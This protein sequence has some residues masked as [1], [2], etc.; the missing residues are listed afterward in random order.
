[1]TVP[2]APPALRPENP[3]SRR[4]VL[5]GPV[6][7]Y[8]LVIFAASSVSNVPALPHGVTDKDAH[9]T[10]YAGL[11]LLFVRALTGARSR[12]VTWWLAAAAVLCATAYGLSDETHQLFVPRRTFDLL[13][14]AADAVGAS[15]GAAAYWLWGII[16]PGFGKPRST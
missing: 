7:L 8:C 14:L 10:L 2:V 15:L 16:G 11:G 13:D 5:W 9:A 12:P 3:W 4:L 6:V 1:V